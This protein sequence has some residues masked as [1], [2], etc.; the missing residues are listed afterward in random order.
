MHIINMYTIYIYY[1]Y[2]FKFHNSL[3]II[4]MYTL[5]YALSIFVNHD[6]PWRLNFPWLQ[7]RSLAKD[8]EAPGNVLCNQQ[9]YDI[10]DITV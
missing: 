9:K 2:I 3:N 4:Y 6:P 5:L 10:T 1:I 8:S 7:A